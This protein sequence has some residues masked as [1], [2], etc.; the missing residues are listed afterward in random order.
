MQLVIFTGLQAA[1]KSSFYRQR[2]AATHVQ[3]SKDLLRNNK[4]PARRQ[5]QLLAE[6]L[7]AGSSV[8][9]DNTNAT[10]AERAELIRLGREHDAEIAGY[11]F[12]PEVKGSLER[13]RR[14]EGHERVP[15]IAIFATLKR[16]TPPTYAEGFDQLY[17][18]RI[19]SEGQFDVEPMPHEEPALVDEKAAD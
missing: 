8:V 1:G 14:R 11:F 16:L 19:T 3:I 7:A 18:V 6:A 9:V 17:T 13:N 5:A 12:V 2:F 15:D 4:R 10:V